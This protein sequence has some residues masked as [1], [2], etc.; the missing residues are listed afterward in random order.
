MILTQPSPTQA[1]LHFRIADIPVRVHPFFWVVA[2]LLG[3]REPAKV[4]VWVVAMFVSILVHELG[5]AVLQRRYG[6]RP[7]IV[8]YS[9]GGL[10]IGEGVRANPWQQILISLAGPFAGFLLAGLLAVMLWASGHGL[11]W[12]FPVVYP[13]GLTN[14]LL[15][16]FLVD[17]FY[18]NIAWGL[19][20]LLPIY[21]LDG[22]QAAREL[23]TLWMP[24]HKGVVAS[25]WVSVFC[26]SGV[27]LYFLQSRGANGA[28]SL[29]PV[30]MF[31]LLAYSSY[32]TLQAYQSSYGRQR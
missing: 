8:L 3:P 4:L 11:A 29:L 28:L 32:Q 20:N 24:P 26:A 18:V 17:L 9:F 16:E 31:G 19:L 22:G 6:G 7:R 2:L 25:L 5:H 21:P 12:K 13:V 27:A 23:F 14:E 30:I 10:A 15:W 1:D